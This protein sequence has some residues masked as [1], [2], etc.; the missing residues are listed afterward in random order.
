MYTRLLVRDGAIGL[1]KSIVDMKISMRIES[2]CFKEY[3]LRLRCD[4]YMYYVLEVILCCKCNAECRLGGGL[5]TDFNWTM[6]VIDYNTS[7]PI[8]IL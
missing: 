3:T 1:G 2:T 6:F 4:T 5:C 7:V 8:N